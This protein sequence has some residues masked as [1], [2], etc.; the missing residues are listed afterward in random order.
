MSKYEEAMKTGRIAR[1]LRQCAPLIAIPES[2]IVDRVDVGSG[3]GYKFIGFVIRDELVDEKA[4]REKLEEILND[5][6]LFNQGNIV[7]RA[8]ELID[9]WERR[10]KESAIKEA[11]EVLK[12][13]GN[14]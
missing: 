7:N 4:V 2:G 3:K 10:F 5:A 9:I 8:Q 13:F 11:Q 14:K 6:L 1:K 12:D